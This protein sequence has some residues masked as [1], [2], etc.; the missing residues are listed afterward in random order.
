[1]TG[2]AL[3]TLAPGDGS[4]VGLSGVNLPALARKV[5]QLMEGPL[6]GK[7]LLILT[8]S[9]V[10]AEDLLGD[11][12][13]FWP[14]GKVGVLSGSETKPFIGQY[15]GP[16]AAAERLNSLSLLARDGFGA[17]VVG[18]AASSLRLVPS[19]KNLEARTLTITK[20]SE[21]N[22]ENLKEYLE[23]NGY[24][25]VG[26]VEST[27]DYAVRGGLID[28]FPGGA[29]RPIRVDFF[30]DFVESIRTFRITDQRSVGNLN[31]VVLTP[32]S[33]A[34]TGAFDRR[35]AA[36]KL[37]QM[38]E[39]S[40]WHSLLWQPLLN[41][42]DEW[43]LPAE[44]EQWGPLYNPPGRH[45]TDYLAHQNS[46]LL[47][48]EPERFWEAATSTYLGISNHF[49]RLIAEERPHLP[50][51]WLFTD[52]E[53][54]KEDLISLP[55]GLT[56]AR[57]LSIDNFG[58][59]TPNY[60]IRFDCESNND[61][62]ALMNVPRRATGFLG[63]LAARLKALMGRGFSVR[64]VLRTPEQSRR[65]AE[66]L[67]EYDLSPTKTLAGK[68][69]F[70][71]L[72]FDVGQI[73]GGFASPS[74]SEAYIAEDEI[75][76]TRQRLRR[77]SKEEFRGLKGFSAL[78]DLSTGDY[79][80]HSEHGIGQY[81]GLVT[82][83]LSS[84]QKGDFLHLCYRGGD[85]LY[86]P[87][88]RFKS[89][90][91]YVGPSDHPPLLDRLGSGSWEK[92]KSK[93]KEN[94]REM[95]EELLKL[96]A[97]RQAT[98]GFSFSPRDQMLTEFEAA[99]QYDPTPD[100]ERAIDDVLADLAKA[101]PMDRLVCGD[102]GYG[103]TEVAM[104]AA[105]KVICD[106]KQVAVLVPTTILAEQ[107]E[108]S[109]AERLKNWPVTVASLS[110]FKK[111]AE[112]K[113][114]LSHL[115]NGQVDVVIGTHR[116][117]QKDVRFKDLGLLVIDEEHRFGVSDK[118]KLKKFRAQVDVLSMSATPIPRSLSMS[119]N[120]IRDM[121]VIE[122][123]PQD[124]LAIRTKIIRRTDEAI[125][126]A[127]DFELARGGQVFFIHNQVRDIDRVVKHLSELMPL[128]RF[129]VGHGQMSSSELEKALRRF[130]NREIDVWVATSIVESGL[131][132]PS[133]NTMIIDRSDRFGLAQLYQ[134]R[135]RV[136]RGH[137]Q[138]YCY[139]MVDDPE[140]LT[141]DARKRLKALL[142]HTDL[143]SGYQ[144]AIHD[145]QIRGSGNILGTAQSGQASL[146]GFEMYAQLMEQTIREIKNEPFQE[147]YEPEVVVGLPAF[148]PESYAKDTE[149]RLDIYRRLSTA[150]TEEEAL[151]ITSEME[152]RLGPLPQ[153]AL[154][155][156]DLTCVKLRLRKARVRRLE[157]GTEGLTLTFGPEGPADYEKVLALVSSGHRRNRLTPQ[158][159]LIVNKTEYSNLGRPLEGVKEFLLRLI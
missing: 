120:G 13:Y 157:G 21:T 103:K 9:P 136:G 55:Q 6:K 27:A 48:L 65:L 87:V 40:G 117:L 66:M 7:K 77:R 68:V 119:M 106:R 24:R 41:R 110:R 95:A 101:K 92:V 91:K 112:Q 98:D 93:V 18:W 5:S 131:D 62:R 148:L 50:K 36:K 84:G 4:I 17:V 122:T 53:K 16:A 72:A 63:P 8:P 138:A 146:V 10:E 140:T 107:H 159:K 35:E 114:I 94:I 104:R 67:L 153:E 56:L 46:R 100:Q 20:G 126:D 88:E 69:N 156:I 89:V 145:L 135:G 144:I 82:L 11:L 30:G 3:R 14:D 34:P 29:E 137:L 99:F 38:A 129:G 141:T 2:D 32:A 142:D 71:T 158:G 124:R 28:L 39:H 132:F 154:N 130:L 105:F 125:C 86:V 108:K 23:T 42:L 49:S 90:S 115:A 47:I 111:P 147:D 151:D 127:I 118:E 150:A 61:L 22:Y 15:S 60:N 59:P 128:V 64:L 51:Q 44:M 57:E 58:L 33:E 37:K 19:V 102:V 83:V 31:S 96:Y 45:I 116:L 12:S 75:F 134:L 76:G 52:P 73:S 85:I 1:M 78:R 139:L 152:D 97:L 79:V 121:S 133:A 123:S 26:L 80:V 149:V 25:R 70:G 109:F 155:L 143:G 43:P 113:E 74:D 81:L 54:L